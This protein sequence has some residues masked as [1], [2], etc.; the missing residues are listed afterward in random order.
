M[1]GVV[2]FSFFSLHKEREKKEG[3]T[4]ALLFYNPIWV[5]VKRF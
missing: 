2:Y 4:I 3:T 1:F 5:R